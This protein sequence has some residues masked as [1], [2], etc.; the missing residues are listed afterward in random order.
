MTTLHGVQPTVKVY[1]HV[2]GSGSGKRQI[3]LR[4]S[5]PVRSNRSR[6]NLI[7]M[8]HKCTCTNAC[9][10]ADVRRIT[11]ASSRELSQLQIG[12]DWAAVA[13]PG[14]C[15]EPASYRPYTLKTAPRA[16]VH[17]FDPRKKEIKTHHFRAQK[18]HSLMKCRWCIFSCFLRPYLAAMTATASGS[19]IPL[20]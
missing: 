15:F 2:H 1:V 4:V 5:R 14:P 19:K 16:N 7:L 12:A 13:I 3:Y 11:H 6:S 9:K 10:L 20:H 18:L 17:S 8:P